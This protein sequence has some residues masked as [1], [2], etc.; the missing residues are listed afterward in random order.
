MV[1]HKL[2]SFTAVVALWTPY[3]LLIKLIHILLKWK[4]IQDKN[5]AIF[6][7]MLRKRSF[8]LFVCLVFVF[9]FFAKAKLFSLRSFRSGYPSWS[10]HPGK[11]SPRFP[12]DLG[13]GFRYE[14]TEIFT[15]GR[16][17]RRDLG[18]RRERAGLI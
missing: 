1:E 7:A 5:Y 3:I 18:N 11:F 8:F 10:V 17:A 6:A 9:F 13:S 14:H 12:R 2:V 16:V 4:Y 15:N